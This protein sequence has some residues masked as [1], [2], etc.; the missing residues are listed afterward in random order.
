MMQNSY[1]WTLAYY[2]ENGS[3]FK[4]V[5]LKLCFQ[6]Q[7]YAQQLTFLLECI[8]SFLTVVLD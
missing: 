1:C 7:D 8:K 5:M 6:N 3:K 2:A 4:P